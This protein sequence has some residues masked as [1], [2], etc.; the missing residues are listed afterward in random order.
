MNKMNKMKRHHER[1]RDYYRE[2]MEI[3]IA[4]L[5]KMDEITYH[6]GQ[7]FQLR[8][9]TIY[10]LCQVDAYRMGL[11]SMKDGNG[12]HFPPTTVKDGS[13]ITEEEF[14]IIAGD[15]AHCFKLMEN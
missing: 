14:D 12:W 15:Q 7:N 5:K 11:I 4:V 1:W 10:K 2:K 9:G 13:E 8:G 3:E 6:C